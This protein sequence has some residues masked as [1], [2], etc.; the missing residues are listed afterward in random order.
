[1]VLKEL[2]FPLN[3]LIIY[4]VHVDSARRLLRFLTTYLW[5]VTIGLEFMYDEIM[6]V[7]G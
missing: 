4:F 1:M 6:T 2:A 3:L 7:I 5:G